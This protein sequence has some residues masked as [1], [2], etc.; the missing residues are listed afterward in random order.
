V[1]IL[2]PGASEDERRAVGAQVDEIVD[3]GGKIPE[4]VVDAVARVRQ[5]H[6]SRE[7]PRTTA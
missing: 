7:T 3:L 1:A 2:A 4:D 5:K 6:N